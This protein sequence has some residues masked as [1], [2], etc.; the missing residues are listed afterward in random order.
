MPLSRAVD[1]PLPP[2][3]IQFIAPRSAIDAIDVVAI[4][5]EATE[6]GVPRPDIDVR[7]F[8]THAGWTRVTCP[9]EM[10]LRLLNAWREAVGRTRVDAEAEERLGAMRQ[11]AVA[12][13]RAYENV[14][15]KPGARRRR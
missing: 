7:P 9:V 3:P 14:R 10:T 2:Q 5:R 1:K 15:G 4:I 13:Y 11:A 6:D 12:A 8:G